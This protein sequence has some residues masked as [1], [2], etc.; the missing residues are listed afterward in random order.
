MRSTVIDYKY[1]L[2]QFKHFEM[3]I[4]EV[5]QALKREEINNF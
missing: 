3:A 1:D 2:I 4:F 5:I